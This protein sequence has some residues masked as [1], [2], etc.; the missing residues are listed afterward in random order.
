[1]LERLLSAPMEC[2]P[3]VL[4]DCG[5]QARFHEMRSKQLL[6]VLGPITIQRP[7]YLCPH[8]HQGQSP[9]DSEL[10]VKGTEY[11]PGVRRMMA[12]V[13]SDTSFEHGREEL[14]LLAGC[15]R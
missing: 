14:E 3:G 10:D 6:T 11:S 15:S 12:V 9:R 5:Q 2:E 4:C 8:C 13:G 7:Y 1:M